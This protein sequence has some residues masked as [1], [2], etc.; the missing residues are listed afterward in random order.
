MLI[1]IDESGDPGL[2]IGQGSSKFFIVALV[3]FEENDEAV[4]CDQRIELLKRELGW[5]SKDEFHFKNNSNK[6]REAFLMAVS[7]YSFFYYGIVMNKTQLWGDG[8]RDKRSFYKYSCSL[9]FENAKEKLTNAIIVIDESGNKDFRQ[10]LQRYLKG[11]M[12]D[13]NKVI[14]K[15]K[16]QR[17]TGNNLLQLADYVAGVINR[18]I[19]GKRKEANKFRKMISHREIHVQIWPKIENS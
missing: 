5:G 6:V 4:A 1:F 12:N 8:F 11:K 9:V 16:M 2:K 19:G 15:I 13:S 10:Q 17:S 7:P 3:V 14:K 18:S